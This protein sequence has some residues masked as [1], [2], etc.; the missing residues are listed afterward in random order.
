MFNT[1]AIYPLANDNCSRSV[2]LASNSHS[3][4]RLLRNAG[5][6][7]I[8]KVPNIAE[9]SLLQSLQK[10]QTKTEEAAIF[11]A[12]LK[13]IYVSHKYPNALVIGSDQ[14]LDCVGS[15]LT[16]PVDRVNA[17]LTL[18]YLSGKSHRLVTAVVAAK[19]GEKIWQTIDVVTISMRAMSES[20]ID[21]YLDAVGDEIYTSVG[22][23][24][25]E[26]YGSQLFTKLDGDYFTALGLPL[27]QVLEF[28]RIHGVLVR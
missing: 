15:W 17:E 13:A 27:F 14:I 12:E 10:K 16:K 4:A 9:K 22:A 23:Y 18:R 5:V 19:A 26:S 8:I 28:L 25:L 2:I 7:F 3:R 21:R 6:P 1:R 20:F 24:Q 11:L